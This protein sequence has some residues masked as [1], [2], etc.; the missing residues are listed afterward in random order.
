MEKYP[1]F[2]AVLSDIN[3]ELINAYK[4]VKD[5]VE[6]LIEMLKTHKA[7]YDE[8][9]EEYYYK[10]R[11]QEPE[12]CTERAARLIFLNKTCYNG[13]Y[14]VNRKGKFNVPFGRYKNP[15]IPDGDNLRNAS[16]VL[17]VS[18]AKLLA[19][20]YQEATRNASSGTFIYFD[21]P[22]QPVSPTASFTNYTSA[23]FSLEEQKRL[24]NWFRELDERGCQVLLSNSDTKE[25][26]D[27]YEGY[28]I[29]TVAAIRAINCKGEKR[30]GHTELIIRNY[31]ERKD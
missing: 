6:H 7:S 29:E 25:A 21:P 13:L 2:K 22:Y 4:V 31:Y 14:R 15:K 30:K 27:I 12:D 18:N 1:P 19:T 28:Q 5:N 3:G 16:R 26:R 9:P 24:G 17:E 10:V 20:D 11:S 8:H 23:G